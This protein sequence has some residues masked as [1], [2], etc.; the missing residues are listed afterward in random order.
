MK[1]VRSCLTRAPRDRGYSLERGDGA[2]RCVVPSMIDASSSTSPRTFGFPP[3][4]TLVS[5]G[6]ASMIL[7]HASTASSAVPP[8]LST[9]MPAGS[10]DTPL[11]LATMI[12]AVRATTSGRSSRERHESRRSRRLSRRTRASR[13]RPLCE[14]PCR[15]SASCWSTREWPEVLE[16]AGLRAASPTRAHRVAGKWRPVPTVS[17]RQY[18]TASPTTRRRDLSTSRADVPTP[19]GSVLRLI[20]NSA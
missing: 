1:R 2:V 9:R 5:V 12:A 16:G 20:A 4:P 18:A 8:R 10:A 19:L 13:D 3:R 11:P 17:Q 15:R 14:E 7:A 6:S